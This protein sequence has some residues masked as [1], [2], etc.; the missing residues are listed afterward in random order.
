MS[1]KIRIFVCLLCVV[2][3]NACGN[4]QNIVDGDTDTV[5]KD[6]GTGSGVESL[7]QSPAEDQTESEAES[8][9]EPTED[10]GPPTIRNVDWEAYQEVLTDE[11][12]AALQG[13]FPVLEGRV[14]FTWTVDAYTYEQQID[15]RRVSMDEFRYILDNE[16]WEADYD[17]D[18][19][20]IESIALCDLDGDGDRELILLLENIGGH[21]LILKKEDGRYYGTNRV[22]RGFESLQTNGVYEG[23]GGAAYSYYYRMVFEEETFREVLLGYTDWDD[24]ENT[25]IYYMGDVETADEE[26]FQEWLEGILSEEVV[27]YKP[28]I[29]ADDPPVEHMSVSIHNEEEYQAFVRQLE[30]SSGCQ[31]LYL[32]MEDSETEVYLD[33]LMAACP[34]LTYLRI[35][36]GGR[37]AA[38]D[39]ESLDTCALYVLVLKSVLAVEED[40][41]RH[42]PVRETLYIEMDGSYE[43]VVPTGELLDNTVC[44]DL[45]LV[46]DIGESPGLPGLLTGEERCD[47]ISREWDDVSEMLKRG[48]LLGIHRINDGG[49]SYTCFDFYRP[50]SVTELCGALISVRDSGGDEHFAYFD[51]L[52]IPEDRLSEADMRLGRRIYREEDL[53]FDGVRDIVYTGT[54]DVRER[55]GDCTVFLW[56]E[57]EDKYVFCESAPR[58]FLWPQQDRQRII[59]AAILGLGETE[60][61]HIYEYDGTGFTDRKLEVSFAGEADI[62][63]VSWR[64]FEEGELRETLE[65]TFD[66][67]SGSGHITYQGNGITEE[68]ELNQEKVDYREIGQKYFPEF[69]FYWYG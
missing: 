52:E 36:S 58:D 5:P 10:A 27:Y 26:V 54:G 35:E 32:D 64:Y 11:E 38:R 47:S 16:L 3:L 33:D 25:G 45:I 7:S 65:M 59:D 49:Y 56:D 29:K 60:E 34:G 50:D 1:V 43:G 9:E 69:D 42:I 61:Y 20:W 67:S 41:L 63:Q 17:P 46:W 28:E 12:Y 57:K 39:A 22:Y 4:S 51:L 2:F 40:I 21:Y 18:E 55:S 14:S 24:K 53:N 62:E 44:E 15:K 48:K 31:D 23:S 6:S 68:E 13:F 37:I 30:A 66:K 8:Q 19:L